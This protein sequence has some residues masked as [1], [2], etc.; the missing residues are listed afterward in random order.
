MCVPNIANTVQS[1]DSALAFVQC[2]CPNINNR[3]FFISRR[4]LVSLHLKFIFIFS[5]LLI[6]NSAH[7]DTSAV[8]CFVTIVF[9][10]DVYKFML[11]TDFLMDFTYH[12]IPVSYTHLDV[13][14]RQVT[15]CNIIES[16]IFL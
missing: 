1:L 12:C 7:I 14:K 2:V 13:Y 10:S 9:S 8:C 6:S 16:F 15:I 5:L 3:N 11:Q 4:E